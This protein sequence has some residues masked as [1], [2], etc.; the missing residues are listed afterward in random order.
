MVRS[1]RAGFQAR[2]SDGYNPSPSY[3]VVPPPR[4]ILL[5]YA[6]AC[7][8]LLP[9]LFSTGCPEATVRCFSSDR[10]SLT[11]SCQYFKTRFYDNF[12]RT[13]LTFLSEDIFIA[14]LE[15]LPPPPSDCVYLYY[16][17][18]PGFETPRFRDKF[19][20]NQLKLCIEILNSKIFQR[21]FQRETQGER[22]R[23]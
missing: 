3:P 4:C 21:E 22:R 8:A 10:N 7:P 9:P 23:I 19:E 17:C 20:R 2:M 16:R 15:K 12:T 14:F 13:T 1:D 5:V 11:H 6:P 18:I